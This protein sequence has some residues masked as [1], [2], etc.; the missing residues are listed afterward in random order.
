MNDMQIEFDDITIS[1][2]AGEENDTLLDILTYGGTLTGRI[3]LLDQESEDPI[4]ITTSAEGTVI[5]RGLTGGTW[6]PGRHLHVRPE[7]LEP[8]STQSITTSPAQHPN[9]KEYVDLRP[10]PS[11]GLRRI[12]ARDR[13]LRSRTLAWQQEHGDPVERLGELGDRLIGD[14]PEDVDAWLAIVH[15]PY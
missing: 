9:R 3:K 11:P 13:A 4:F 5:A 6:L 1:P 14:S 12:L 10:V 15:E 8:E 7:P 2:E